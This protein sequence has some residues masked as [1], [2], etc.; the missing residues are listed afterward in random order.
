MVDDAT[1]ARF[2]AHFGNTLPAM[3][4]FYRSANGGYLRDK[5]EDTDPSGTVVPVTA[6]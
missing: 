6:Q 3:L 5:E 2:N 4:A 1:L